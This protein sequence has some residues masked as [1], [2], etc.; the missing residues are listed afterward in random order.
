[1]C[2]GA[3]WPLQMIAVDGGL[4]PRVRGSP[5]VS[6]HRVADH[7]SIPACAGEPSGTCGR[8]LRRKV[9]PRVCG[10]ASTGRVIS[11]TDMGLSPRVRGSL[12][13]VVPAARLVRSI[14][15]CAGEPDNG[16]APLLF[17][18]VYPRVCGGAGPDIH[19]ASCYGGLSPR[20]RGS[21]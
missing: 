4:S 17:N 12:G 8:C 5:G 15:A 19:A 1:M 21:L 13:P 9:Y 16:V 11:D 20:V 10:G 7:R 2:G 18:Q 3:T 14:P 6:E